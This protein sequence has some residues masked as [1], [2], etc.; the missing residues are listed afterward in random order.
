MMNSQSRQNGPAIEAHF[1]FLLWLGPTVEN[2]PRDQK[3]ILGDRMQNTAL[4]VL[5]AL[6]EATYTRERRA[7][8]ARANLGLEKLRFFF[9]IAVER[10]H[11]DKRRYEFA[12][13]AIDEAAHQTASPQDHHPANQ[14]GRAVSR[15]GPDAR[16]K[17]A[18]A[19]GKCRE[20]PKPA[21][22]FEA[23]LGNRNSRMV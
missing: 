4:D 18:A 21:G 22:R 14:H 8:L 12:A 23:T 6:I 19:G 15:L 13:R 10:Q 9:R 20:V 7:S 11:I 3:F 5:E 16:W 1:R 2:F 17:K